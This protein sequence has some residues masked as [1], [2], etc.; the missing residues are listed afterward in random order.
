MG[1]SELN[2]FSFV[3]EKAL[4]A[5]DAPAGI[6]LAN[7]LS[8]DLAVLAHEPAAG[9]AQGCGGQ[10]GAAGGRHSRFRG[11]AGLSAGRGAGA[12]GGAA[13]PGPADVRA[14]ARAFLAGGHGE[15]RLFRSE[16]RG[17]AAGFVVGR[18]RTALAAAGRGGAVFA[19]RLRRGD[20]GRGFVGARL[21]KLRDE[22]LEH[23]EVDGGV[24]AADL[25][26]EA[27]A[28]HCDMA[29]IYRPVSKF[30][31][32][33]RDLAVVVDADAPV[34]EMLA[35]IGAVNPERITRLGVFDVYMGKGV[36]EG[37]KSVAFSMWF[38]DV[39]KSLA[40]KD[41][42]K[43]TRRILAALERSCGASLRE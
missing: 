19:G 6:R 30:P 26:L 20:G 14:A 17:R 9:A 41:A 24:F 38:Q 5:V 16:G 35:T 12:A 22:V 8:E 11:A 25:D 36:P 18:G 32:I 43:L 3:E 2:S 33:F 4:A 13:S 40:D 37:K 39:G 1:L 7:P 28:E 29:T 27:L 31:P 42:D 23:F 10:P 15:D 34:D 21:G